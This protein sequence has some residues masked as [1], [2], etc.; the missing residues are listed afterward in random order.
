MWIDIGKLISEHVPDKNG[1]LL[2]PGVTH[3]SYEF[4]DLTDTGVG[5]LF[6]GKLTYDKTYGHAV[7]GCAECCAYGE[8]VP[9]YV[10]IDVVILTEVQNGVNGLDSCTGKMVDVS[11]TFYNNWSSANTAIVTVDKYGNHTGKAAGSTTTETSGSLPKPAARL[12]PAL[13]R[14]PG[15][16]ANV[17]PTITGPS[18]LWWFKGLAAGVSGYANQITLTASAGIGTSYQWAI[19]AGSD[20]VSL[21]TSTSATI[22][23]TS[24]GQSVTANDVSITVTAGGITSNPFKISVRA[25]YTLGTD[26]SNPVPIYSQDPSYVWL[27]RIPYLI[28]DNFL[29]AIPSPVPTNENWTTPEVPDYTN[30]NWVRHVPGCDPDTATYAPASIED[31]IQGEY[32]SFFPTPVYNPPH[33]NG[34][35]VEHW[36][37]EIRIGTCQ[38]GSGP[39]VQTDTI[40]KYTDHAAHTAITSP[41]P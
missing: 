13:Q 20:K 35:A 38:I 6:E 22:Q 7:Y 32:P 29:T 25:P 21:S 3:G 36:G 40:Q 18:T 14:F 41:A 15:G 39:R 16:G 8:T 5:S 23:V 1:N 24:T 34:P 37:Q 30:E 9:W 27:I 17:L 11:Q 31:N 33:P 19:T 28:L 12:C 4:R 10:P 2:P 26:P